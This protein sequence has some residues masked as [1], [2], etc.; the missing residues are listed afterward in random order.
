MTAA[1]QRAGPC[2][3][4]AGPG[5]LCFS[6]D[7]GRTRY[8][9]PSRYRSERHPG[10]PQKPPGERL[11]DAQQVRCRALPTDVGRWRAAARRDGL[12]L[13]AWMRAAL[14]EKYKRHVRALRRRQAGQG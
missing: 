9:H 3:C 1:Q 12:S 5:E 7:G 2:K 4:G 10:R 11:R 14:E 13:E 6:S 8:I